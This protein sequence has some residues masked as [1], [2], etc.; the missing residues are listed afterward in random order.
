MPAASTLALSGYCFGAF[1]SG[2]LVLGGGEVVSAGAGVVEG[3]SD[4]VGAGVAV[5][6]GGLVL[7]AAASGGGLRAQPPTRP[8]AAPM[9]RTEAE[10]EFISLPPFVAK[11]LRTELLKSVGVQGFRL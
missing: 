6:A 11:V 1:G 3:I 4:V 9:T 5:C 2:L 7:G 8:K 10:R